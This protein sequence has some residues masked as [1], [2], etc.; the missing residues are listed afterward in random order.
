[1]DAPRLPCTGLFPFKKIIQFKS[2]RSKSQ[3][4]VQRSSVHWLTSFKVQF[5][6]SVQFKY[7]RIKSFSVKSELNE[8]Y[9][10]IK[11]W[12]LEMLKNHYGFVNFMVFLK[13]F[14]KYI[15]SYLLWTELN[16][17][18]W[19]L[20]FIVQ[21]SNFWLRSVQF[22]STNWITELNAVHFLFSSTSLALYRLYR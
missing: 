19:I 5:K 10:Q 21:R 13:F 7:Y 22:S 15:I 20:T 4:F 12:K 9:R 14:E 3:D 17:F 16:N 18:F 2:S 8:F 6:N 1:M 11:F